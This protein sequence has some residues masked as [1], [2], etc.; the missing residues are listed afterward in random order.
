MSIEKRETVK[1]FLAALGHR[2]KKALLALSA[3]RYRVDYSGRRLA[4][5]RR[6]PRARGIGEFA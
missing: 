6:A 4:A 3:E 1:K 2:D 5:G